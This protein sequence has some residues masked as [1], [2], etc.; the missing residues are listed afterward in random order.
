DLSA[1]TAVPRRIGRG[2]MLK[3]NDI[4]WAKFLNNSTF[5]TS[6]NNNVSTDTGVLGLAGLQQADTV[7][8]SQTDP[9]GN[10]LGVRPAIL[11]VPTPLKSTALQLMT[12]EKLKGDADEP[13]ANVWRGRFRV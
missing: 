8:M 7:F 1:L 6:N 3:L 10:P 9:D 4:F 5:F 11:L 13:D 12:S 2:G